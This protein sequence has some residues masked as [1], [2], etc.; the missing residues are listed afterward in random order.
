MGESNDEI[1][2][3]VFHVNGKDRSGSLGSYSLYSD[4][5]INL[6]TSPDNAMVRLA[7]QND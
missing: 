4:P 5:F 7:H 2:R 6:W 3:L 1:R